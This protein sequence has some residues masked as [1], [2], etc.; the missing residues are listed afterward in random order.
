MVMRNILWVDF[1]KH[2]KTMKGKNKMKYKNILIIFL[3]LLIPLLANEK[4]R[5]KGGEKELVRNIV[6][7][8]SARKA[9][10][11]GTVYVN[12]MVDTLGELVYVNINKGVNKDLDWAAILAVKKTKFIP[13]DKNTKIIIPVKFK[14]NK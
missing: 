2:I 1:I 12:T 8:E 14:L 10:I 6:Y 9:G 4:P 11:E 13:G 5:I 7:P 3:L